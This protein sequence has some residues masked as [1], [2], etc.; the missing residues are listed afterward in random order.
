VPQTTF[1]LGQVFRKAPSKCHY[2]T[3]NAAKSDIKRRVATKAKCSQGLC[4]G[5]R[6]FASV[7]LYEHVCNAYILGRGNACVRACP[8]NKRVKP[9]EEEIVHCGLNRCLQLKP[10]PCH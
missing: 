2:V 6:W 10:V 3:L 4:I 1:N 9:G 5:R 7:S 8:A